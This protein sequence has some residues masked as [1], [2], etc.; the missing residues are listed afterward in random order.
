MPS[1]LPVPANSRFLAETDGIFGAS[2]LAVPKM[3]ILFTEFRALRL[4][5]HDDEQRWPD[6]F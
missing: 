4:P 5:S 2:L 6:R 3:S 1:V